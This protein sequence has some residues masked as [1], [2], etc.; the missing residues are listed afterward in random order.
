MANLPDMAQT[1]PPSPSMSTALSSAGLPP[2]DQLL[3]LVLSDARTAR[4][5]VNILDHLQA[6]RSLEAAGCTVREGL[7]FSLQVR[8]SAGHSAKVCMYATSAGTRRL[9]VSVGRQSACLELAP[10]ELGAVVAWLP[11][12]VDALATRQPAPAVPVPVSPGN[13]ERLPTTA[14]ADALVRSRRK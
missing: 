1:K 12:L 10:H 6:R 7:G 2:L 14:A 3:D 11:A 9:S 8:T 4:R 5:L 13:C